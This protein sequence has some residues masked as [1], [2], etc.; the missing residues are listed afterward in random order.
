MKNVFRLVCWSPKGKQIVV[1]TYSGD[2]HCFDSKMNLKNQLP[3][4]F[5]DQALPPCI[6][7]VWI[8]TN[9][10]LLSFSDSDPDE[11]PSDSNYFHV[12]LTYEKVRLVFFFSL[13]IRRFS[14]SSSL[15]STSEKSRFLRSFLRCRFNRRSNQCAILFCSTKRN[16]RRKQSVCFFYF[17]AFCFLF[18]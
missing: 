5:V 2:L 18:L 13:K 3:S 12:L 15:G 9:E 8:S 17:N 1:A 6:N 16:V 10:F 14:S 4:P 7:V 11:N